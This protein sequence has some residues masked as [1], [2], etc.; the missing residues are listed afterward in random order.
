MKVNKRRY[1]KNTSKA[2]EETEVCFITPGQ[3]S[4]AA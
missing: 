4:E 3:K 1:L 2:K